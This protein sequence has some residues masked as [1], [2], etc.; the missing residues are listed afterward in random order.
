MH[1]VHVA[2]AV[3]RSGHQIPGLRVIGNYERH[4]GKGI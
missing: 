4:M 2:P 3:S 1:H